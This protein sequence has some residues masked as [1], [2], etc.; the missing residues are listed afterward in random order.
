MPRDIPESDWKIFRDL[1]P[2]ALNR[3]CEEI[4][5]DVRRQTDRPGKTAHEKYLALYKLLHQRDK[6]IA[7]AFNDFRRSTA[8]AQ[9][10]IIHSQGLFTAEELQRFSPMTREILALYAPIP[11]AVGLAQQAKR[12]KD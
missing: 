9:L 5:T 2:V 12:I 3:L 1:R 8:L 7:R 6:D 11:E 4:L 10:G